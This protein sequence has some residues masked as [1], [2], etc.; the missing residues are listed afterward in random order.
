MSAI[1]TKRTSGMSALICAFNPKAD[2][3]EVLPVS[4]FEPLR[5]P[6]YSRNHHEATRLH[7][8]SRWRGGDA[9]CCARSGARRV[10]RIGVLLPM[11]VDDAEARPPVRVPGRPRAIGLD[12]R[13]QRAYRGSLVRPRSPPANRRPSWRRSRRMSSWPT[14][15]QPGSVA[16]G[17][18]HRARSCSRSSRPGRRRFRRQPGTAWR[19]RHRIYPCSNTASS[20]KWLE[21]LKQIAPGVKR[22]AVLRDADHPAG[23]GQFGAIQSARRRLEWN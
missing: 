3:S 8:G 15:T 7:R 20:G 14:A 18:A 13:P 19:Q 12:R 23:I 9:A 22:A 16:P 4:L 11:R 2:I 17:D 6:S 5:C 21:L 10:R 1:G